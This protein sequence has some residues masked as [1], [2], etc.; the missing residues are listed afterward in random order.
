MDEQATKKYLGAIIVL[1]IVL[2]LGLCLLLTVRVR[3]IGR[4]N[5]ISSFRQ[6]LDTRKTRPALVSTTTRQ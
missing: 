2:L 3:R 4:E 1:M 5:S 6:L